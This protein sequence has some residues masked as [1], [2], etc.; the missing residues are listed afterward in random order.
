MKTVRI[1][2]VYEQQI[3]SSFNERILSSVKIVLSSQ[4][5]YLYVIAVQPTYDES[6]K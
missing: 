2:T 5:T 3:L 1:D 4:P 6:E